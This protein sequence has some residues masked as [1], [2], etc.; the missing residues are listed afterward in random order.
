MTSGHWDP[1]LVAGLRALAEA[2]FPKRCASCG[3]VYEDVHDYVRRTVPISAT[4]SGLKQSSDDDG[5]TIVEMFRN[6]ACGSTLMD[7]FND[8]RDPSEAGARRRQRFAELLTYLV[9]A[10]LDNAVARA[11]LL[12]V[13]HGGT[14]EVLA[15]V[16][17]PKK[18]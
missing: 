11:E 9:G 5:Q 13:M 12:K 14:S 16:K 6:C 18:G 15:R 1:E 2:S 4:R 3:A 8:R 17:P 7:F 10:G